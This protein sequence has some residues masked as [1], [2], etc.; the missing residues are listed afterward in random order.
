MS[1]IFVSLAILG[2]ILDLILF[3]VGLPQTFFILYWRKSRSNLLGRLLGRAGYMVLANS[4]LSSIP[5][6]A[7]HMQ[8]VPSKSLPNP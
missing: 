4:V 1:L 7:M 6:Y 2:D 8:W 3:M 5:T